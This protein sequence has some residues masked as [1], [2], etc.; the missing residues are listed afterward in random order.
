M[1]GPPVTSGPATMPGPPFA[2]VYDEVLHPYGCASSYCHYLIAGPPALG[3]MQNTY[4]HLVGVVSTEQGC[5]GM[6][7]VVPGDPEQSL[8]YL[9][10]SMDKPPCGNRMPSLGPQGAPLDPAHVELIRAWIAGGAPE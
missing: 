6:M 1:P 3:P 8:L 7:L 5:G 2:E 4:D 9:K 10:V